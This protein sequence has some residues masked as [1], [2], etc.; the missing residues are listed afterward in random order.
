MHQSQVTPA[1]S[2]Q[3]VIV[4]KAASFMHCII[5][6]NL[7]FKLAEYIK[8]CFKQRVLYENCIYALPLPQFY[9]SKDSRY[10]LSSFTVRRRR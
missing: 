9:H 6:Y 10:C 5:K 2:Q 7:H 4:N 3:G 8:Y 1:F